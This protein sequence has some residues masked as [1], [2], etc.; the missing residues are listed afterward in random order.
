MRFRL[1]AV[2]CAFCGLAVTAS[3]QVTARLTGSVVDPSGAPVPGAA[4][5]VYLPGGAKPFVTMPTTA[6]GLFAFIAVPAGTYDV[7]VTANGFRKAVS[8]GITLVAAQETPLPVLSGWQAAGIFLH[9]SGFPYSICSG[10]GTFNRNNVL[11]T[12]EC[13]TVDTTL[14]LSQLQTVMQFRMTGNGPY[15]VAASAIGSDG[16]AANPGT[17]P[18]SGQVFTIPAAGAIESLQQRILTGP[19]DT[20]FDFGL[21]KAT[22]V[23]ERHEVDFR[24]DAT[25]FFNHPAFS[26]GDQTVTSTTFGKITSTFNARRQ[27]QFTLAYR[28]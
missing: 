9:Q 22:K 1:G 24:M 8:R 27:I 21:L 25:N 19:W 5:E 26:I 23:R 6:D 7:T 12:N 2:L 15:M 20:S 14:M 18:F 13:N 3:A 16:R 11:A 10:L 17:T 28:F 4:V